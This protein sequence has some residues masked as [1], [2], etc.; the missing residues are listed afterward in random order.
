MHDKS[1]C[2]DDFPAGTSNLGNTANDVLPPMQ[3]LPRP[4]PLILQL[5][6]KTDPHRPLS[7]EQHH[8]LLPAG[9]VPDSRRN[10]ERDY[11]VEWT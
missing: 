3:P 5:H 1:T 7:I 6:L 2:S 11:D 4:L 10:R 9:C 8:H